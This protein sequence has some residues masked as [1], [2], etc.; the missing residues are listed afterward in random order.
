MTEAPFA[1]PGEV[2]PTQAMLGLHHN[3]CWLKNFILVHGD[4]RDKPPSGEAIDDV[5]E[6]IERAAA[7]LPAPPDGGAPPT[8]QP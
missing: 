8:I 7:R 6:Y 2:T 5:C 3:L 1:A 4:L